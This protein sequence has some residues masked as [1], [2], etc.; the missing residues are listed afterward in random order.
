MSRWKY[1]IVFLLLIMDIV[2]SAGAQTTTPTPETPTN[3]KIAFIGDQ[4]LGKDAEEVLRI[5]K[6]EG[7]QTM[8]HIGVFD[9]SKDSKRTTIR[10][11]ACK[12]QEFNK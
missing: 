1:N 3:F 10:V 9:H 12:I 7:A 6:S 11:S 5:I 4:G 8:L 2:G